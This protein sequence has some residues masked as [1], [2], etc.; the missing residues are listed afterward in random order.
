MVPSGEG[1]I[2]QGGLF[3]VR[4]S[5]VD[6]GSRAGPLLRGRRGASEGLE[7]NFRQRPSY[8]IQG[9]VAPGSQK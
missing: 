4:A 7:D 2:I 1:L 3:T 8:L 5:V 9:I 6:S